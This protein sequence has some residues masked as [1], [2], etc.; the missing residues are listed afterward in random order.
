MKKTVAEGGGIGQKEDD[1]KGVERKNTGDR[2]NFVKGCECSRGGYQREK[3]QFLVVMTLE[4]LEGKR[5]VVGRNRKKGECIRKVK[6]EE[7]Q[8]VRK[9]CT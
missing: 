2:I 3:A 8:D 9:N 6:R 5:C 4:V 7:R 1:G